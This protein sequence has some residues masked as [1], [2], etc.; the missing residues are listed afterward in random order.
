VLLFST[1]FGGSVTESQGTAIDGSGNVYIAG[2]ALDECGGGCVHFPNTGP[3]AYAGAGDA[4]ISE[5]SADGS[6]ILYATLI[7]GTKFDEASS[8]TVDG[9]G[10]AYITGQTFSSD[11]PTT[12]GTVAT[13]APGGDGDG[14]VAK[15]D[16]SGL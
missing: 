3:P 1:Y 9:G 2:W 10:N 7:G 14:F 16:T 15:F 4:F 11:F 6:T 5:L 13:S 8:V 12:A